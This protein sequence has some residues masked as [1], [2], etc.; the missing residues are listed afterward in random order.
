MNQNKYLSFVSE[1]DKEPKTFAKGNGFVGHPAIAE[2]IAK[3]FSG[4]PIIVL[5]KHPSGNASPL[6]R[7]HCFE[8]RSGCF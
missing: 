7:S 4:A 6:S 8:N 5:E 3:R 1:Y 2:T